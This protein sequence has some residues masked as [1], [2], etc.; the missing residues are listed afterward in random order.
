MGDLEDVDSPEGFT[1]VL[2]ALLDGELRTRSAAS[3]AK[4]AAVAENSLANW[5]AGA[6]PQVAQLEQLLGACRVPADRYG[7]WHGAR[8]RAVRA[9]KAVRPGA[10]SR[11][12]LGESYLLE[13][14]TEL[15]ARVE[16]FGEDPVHLY[17]G[18][19][20]HE[21][22]VDLDTGAQLED[23][24]WM[25]RLTAARGQVG[26]RGFVQIGRDGSLAV[27]AELPQRSG[28]VELRSPWANEREYERITASKSYGDTFAGIG[29]CSDW[30]CQAFAIGSSLF[31]YKGH[32][33][34]NATNLYA[35]RVRTPGAL[36]SLPSRPEMITSVRVAPD[37]DL[38]A[39]VFELSGVVLWD[40]ATLRVVGKPL[41]AS[42]EKVDAM[43]FSPDGSVLAAASGGAV[44]LWDLYSLREQNGRSLDGYTGEVKGLWF[45]PDGR[46]L[47]TSSVRGGVRLWDVATSAG[48]RSSCPRARHGFAGCVLAR[49]CPPGCGR[50]CRGSRPRPA[51]GYLRFGDRHCPTSRSASLPRRTG[52]APPALSATDL[53]FYPSETV[54]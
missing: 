30:T 53:W 28:Q 49:R 35:Q 40:P 14:L 51:P 23:T 27:C 37:G 44:Y 8:E 50:G 42:G 48:R 13:G 38:V 7:A 45:S 26:E 9:R 32:T 2:V 33:L 31:I 11:G 6:I 43:E 39:T 21:S 19:R 24:A 34:N 10:R 29:H 4:R 36:E 3:L 1:A 46:L 52:A 25:G 54:A 5:R 20:G 15:P 17:V 47:T 22:F 16:I 18:T 12:R 41:G